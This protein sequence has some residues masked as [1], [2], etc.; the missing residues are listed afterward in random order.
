MR[1]WLLTAIVS[2][3]STGAAHAQDAAAGEKVF[4][5]CRAPRCVTYPGEFPG[6]VALQGFAWCPGAE[7]NHRHC[8]FQ[9]RDPE[10]K[11]LSRTGRA[12]AALGL[13]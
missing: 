5:H 8:D 3:I 9:L 4:A 2:L 13:C 12:A 7:S 10:C 11:L 1:Q 6:T